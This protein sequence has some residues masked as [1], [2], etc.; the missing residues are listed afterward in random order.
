MVI[1]APELGM[2]FYFDRPG[3]YIVVRDGRVV[4]RI[5]AATATEAL[6]K[7]TEEGIMYTKV[8]GQSGEEN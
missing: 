7:Q 1:E 3:E 6:A 8:G 5:E 2:E 4:E